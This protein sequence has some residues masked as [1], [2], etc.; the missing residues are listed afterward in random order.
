MTLN[1]C[2]GG[3]TIKLCR[4]LFSGKGEI[5][6][7]LNQGKFAIRIRQSFPYFTKKKIVASFLLLLKKGR[8]K[9]QLIDQF[10][11]IFCHS[12]IFCLPRFG[13]CCLFLYSASGSTIMQNC[14][15]IRNPSFP[16]SY[17]GTSS[18][19]YTIQ[20]CSSGKYWLLAVRLWTVQ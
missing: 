17:T 13:V 8:F 12:I 15:Y 1:H 7:F 4:F 6:R 14:S 16:S 11:R 9:M 2:P 10:T 18:V 3:C 5:Y 19:T 20:K